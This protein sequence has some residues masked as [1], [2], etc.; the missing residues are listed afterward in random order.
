M[1]PDVLRDFARQLF[2]SDVTT[3]PD[4]LAWRARCQPH[5]RAFTFLVDGEEQEEQWTYAQL[6]RRARAIAEVLIAND[7]AG[8]RALL[9]YDAGLEYIAALFGC[10]YAG[11]VAVPVYPPDPFRMDRTL[12]RLQAILA[13]A[14]AAWLLAT[15]ETLDWAGP[16]FAKAPGLKSSLATDECHA[17]ECHEA[18]CAVRSAECGTEADSLAIL[19]Y[20]SGST[21]D[22][23]GVMISHR[24]LMANLTLIHRMVDRDDAVAVSWLPAYHDMGL[25]GVTFQPVFSGRHAV[26]LSP[27]AFMQRPYRWLNAISRFRGTT[28][29]APNFAYDLCVRKVSA[30]ERATLDLSSLVL[31][32]NGAE[33]VRADTL[34][35]FSEAFAPCGFRRE[36]FYPCYG[37]AEATLMVSGGAKNELPIV[38]WFDA[39]ALEHNR[40]EPLST[41]LAPE[42]APGLVPDM[43]AP[44][45][46]PGLSGITPITPA[47]RAGT[48]SPIAASDARAGATRL[49]GSG[50][51][52][53][54]QR[55]VIVDPRTLQPL[56]ECQV[57]E[58]WV[59]G[60][61]IG[62]GYWN[63]PRESVETFAATLPNGDGP[64]LRTGDLGFLDGGELF[65]TGRLK[66]L[67]ILQ[68]RNH[69]PHD[70]EQTV[71][72]S[73]PALKL[74]G[75]AAFSVDVSGQERLV[76]VQEVM[77]PRKVDLPAVAETIR[78][79]IAE[80]HGV[81]AS[82]ICL[83]PAGTLPK[84]SSG[85]TRRSACREFFLAGS[86]GAVFEWCEEE[87]RMDGEESAAEAVSKLTAPPNTP[88][89]CRLAQIWSDV[90]GLDP[91]VGQAF[92]PDSV[93]L[94]QS[95]AGKPDL[96]HCDIHTS[97]FDVGGQSLLAS[98]LAARIQAE[99][100][101]EMPI[102]VLF[103]SPT[104]ARLAAWL[105]G[106]DRQM[107]AADLP[108]LNRAD[109]AAPL[110]LSSFQEQ[111]WFLEQLEPEPRYL[112]SATMRL[113]GPL[114]R[115]VL[116]R[117][118]SAI[119][120]RHEALRTVFCE[121]DGLPFQVLRDVG[122]ADNVAPTLRGGDLGSP[123]ATAVLVTE[124]R[125]YFDL[126][127][128]PLLRASL[129]CIDAN[130]HLLTLTIHH[131]I[132]DGWSLSIFLEELA[133]LYHAEVTRQPANLPPVPLH[134]A[135]FAVWQ[136]RCLATQHVQRQLD[137]WKQQLAD[138]TPLELATDF[139]PAR[140]P[141]QS[142]SDAPDVASRGIADS[143][144]LRENKPTS[145]RGAEERFTIGEELT[146]ALASLG[147]QHDATLYMVLLAAFQSLLARW[148]GQ[149]DVCVGSPISYRPRREFERSIGYFVNTLAL[150][151]DLSGDP[152][153]RELLARVRETVLAAFTN[154]DAPLTAIVDALAPQRAEGRSPL[155][156]VMFVFENLPWQ[157][158]DAAGLSI[159]DVKIDHSRIGG[160]DVALV[161]EQQA[162]SLNA[163]VI[164]NA[165]LF[166]PATIE[167]FCNAF[168]L[169]LAGVAAQ[170]GAPVTSLMLA[171]E[172]SHVFH[173]PAAPLQK[174]SA[175]IHD[176]VSEQANRAP[177]ATAIVHGDRQITYQ[178]LERRADQLAHY[179]HA[180]GVT[181]DMPV[182][183][184]LDRSIEMV[185]A[186]L[187]VLKSGG[188][189]VPLDAAENSERLTAMLDN[190]AARAI[191][192][193]SRTADRLPHHRA[194][195][196]LLDAHAE[197][198]AQAPRQP[199]AAGIGPD[200]L[201]YIIYTS[202]STG[203]PKGV[204]VTHA[205]LANH[206]CAMASLYELGPSDRV[207]QIISPAFDVAAEEIFPTL[208][209]GGA[210]VLGPATNELTGRAILDQCRRSRVSVAHIPPPLLQQCLLE[211]EAAD[212]PLFDHWRVLVVGGEPPRTEMLNQWLVLAAGRVRLLHEYGL[213][214]T[215]ITSLV[216]EVPRSVT[217]WPE[218]RR[219]PIGAPIAGAEAWVLD[220]HRRPVP[221]GA[222]GE[223]Y[224]G[225][226][227]LARGYYRL[228]DQTAERFVPHPLSQQPG[229]RLYRTGDLVRRR[230]DGDLEFLGRIDEQIKL[231]GW[232]IEPREIERA[233]LAHPA[234]GQAAVVA[235]EDAPGAKR[236][237]A[238]VV[239]ANGEMPS[240]QELR[241]WLRGKLPEPMVPSAVVRLAHLPLNRHHKLDVAALPAPS[242]CPAEANGEAI[243]FAAPR[244]ACEQQLATIWQEIL[245]LP[246]VGI[247]DNFFELG[248]DS[249]LS[250]QVVARARQAGLSFN[251]RQLFQH[252]TI[253]E[254]AA[255]EGTGPAVTAE[256]GE[257]SGETPLTPIQHWFL[258]SD[259]IDPH[260]FNQAVMLQVDDRLSADV[261]A[262]LDHLASHHD[263]LRLRFAR[264]EHGWR[265]WHAPVAGSWSL[266]RFDFSQ[267]PADEQI[268]ALE[269][270]ASAMQGGLHLENG[271]LARAGWF[272]LGPRGR[273]LLLVVHHLAIDAVS[274]RM[275]LDD[276]AS[277]W[278]RLN[279]GELPSLPPKTT[280]FQHWSHRLVE[281]SQSTAIA[282]ELPYWRALANAEA[283]CLP[284]DFAGDEN[285]QAS[286][287]IVSVVLDQAR[288][289]A[290]LERANTPY[291]THAPEILLA[292]L[293][294]S[295]AQF[296]GQSSILIDIEGHGRAALFDDVDLSRTVGW[297][298]AGY[299]VLFDAPLYLPP[300]TLLRRT[301]E[302]LRR[303]PGEGVGYGVLRYLSPDAAV[304]ESLASL[305]RAEV[306]FNYLGRFDGALDERSLLARAVEPSG[307]L[308][309]PRAERRHLLEVNLF[310]SGGQLSIE[311]G[312]SRAIHRRE[313]IE[314]FAADYHERLAAV[315]DHCLSPQAGG[316]T[317]SDFP[318]AKTD[319]RE[320]ERISQLLGDA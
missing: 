261:L 116:E 49:V 18:E 228:D 259:P 12:P 273:R 14:G 242:A 287:E 204:E 148:T 270:S 174:L 69:Y 211:W 108:P 156:N 23:R 57:G 318:L 97:F 72:G 68:G 17:A 253:A 132:C 124:C 224:L 300:G 135:D 284:R 308:R 197:S 2:P 62:E 221:V 167:S 158:D 128:G 119:A 202:G 152:S 246:R 93:G 150:R 160:F 319:E 109:R 240:P 255:A 267:L 118:L 268:A 84:T 140:W 276:L 216:Y 153:F 315:I 96:R 184:F 80:S 6:D 28:T 123:L 190:V 11:V 269:R 98:Q 27:V 244:T 46:V 131:L 79:R 277:L 203:R 67:I 258:D 121:R 272:D 245:N 292:A 92:Q 262:A 60:P 301:K 87:W 282:A 126:S 82:A 10:L 206:A 225:G 37:L 163:S 127:H 290:L 161:V 164:Y 210:L 48:T 288:T 40:A 113:R 39:A 168:K 254:L 215:T 106:A 54:S 207:L 64:F 105:D 291:R 100:G 159:G 141:G 172:A 16:L 281:Y 102:R 236:L 117:S 130:E 112:L 189:Y 157:G 147:H 3:L 218:N 316:F 31:A 312:F 180:L 35:R 279:N 134:Y 53:C 42:V 198:I 45:L 115:A 85:K 309:S 155:F 283:G 22:P 192:T 44:G 182:S 58:I 29:A 265:Q 295:L 63:R 78:A 1:P 249:I 30:A 154:A 179:L 314:R 251:P 278:M 24:N 65:I 146:D 234:V 260:H 280:S 173:P 169:L 208:L 176:L 238:Y 186:V 263:A 5:Q 162:A 227:G 73:H 296:I 89:E 70:L 256:Q 52:A 241:Q 81:A 205:G 145:Y 187:A 298:T 293:A 114:D 212:A 181:R 177:E 41:D 311:I 122:W 175:P 9:V 91:P 56:P 101:V 33:A 213:T 285:L 165:E 20:T 294:Q 55:V 137:Y 83:I 305:P 15:R 306:A 271:P 248:G 8:E 129:A 76:I 71:A 142:L 274:W 220:A 50:H 200:N 66:D 239:S 233:I 250:I 19:Q 32:L 193:T 243:S 26:L 138:L 125:D 237:V 74:D 61:S 104:I 110:P 107:P 303:V 151:T 43:V 51:A 307:P 194:E 199:L 217:A 75:G 86:L 223:L 297:F 4:V 38:K 111:L 196:I 289:A 275:L 222:P 219:L 266:E 310:V 247:H 103:E 232:R 144:V 304:R 59:S 201:A 21:G 264:D 139:L 133:A 230:A 195:E 191:I 149:H 226:V 7:A 235:R 34:D 94:G 136:R 166:E 302:T 90:L 178:E 252:Q 257:V 229:A 286:L 183:I 77:R 120:T 299:P 171:D 95:Q 313:T 47:A 185:V 88:T 13:D 170:P 25:I 214:E 188:A 143:A 36:A 317:P 231:R 320:L 209:R 99:F